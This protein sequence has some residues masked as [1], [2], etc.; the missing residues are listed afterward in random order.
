MP[1]GTEKRLPDFTNPA[2]KHDCQE[3]VSLGGFRG[4][5]LYV[6]P[7]HGSILARHGSE[8]DAYSSLPTWVVA[9]VVAQ[10]Q[11]KRSNPLFQ[12]YRRAHVFGLL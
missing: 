12:A 6:C 1:T 11:M 2:Y 10:G 4:H 7:K 8:E 9:Q 3:C 5:D